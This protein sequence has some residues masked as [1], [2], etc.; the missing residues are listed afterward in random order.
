[1]WLRVIVLKSAKRSVSVTVRR[2]APASRRRL[3]AFWHKIA[4]RGFE[5]LA[6]ARVF[7]ES[8]IVRKRFWF[9][10]DEKFIGIDAARFAE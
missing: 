10:I 7:A 6:V 2:E 5:Q 3:A 8:L 9:G 4:E 1:M